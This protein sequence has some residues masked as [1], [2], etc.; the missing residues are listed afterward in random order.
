MF[1]CY[2][3]KYAALNTIFKGTFTDYF[4]KIHWEMYPFFMPNT[5][6]YIL[7]LNLNLKSQNFYLDK[8]ARKN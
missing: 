6:L 2:G 1:P 8:K 4:R 7:F 3:L 5:C